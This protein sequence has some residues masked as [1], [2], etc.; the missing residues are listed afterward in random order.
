MEET[1]VNHIRCKRWHTRVYSYDEET[2][3]KKEKILWFT[4]FKDN[5]NE[6][7]RYLE[8]KH[9]IGLRIDETFWGEPKFILEE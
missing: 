4:G 8:E 3:I 6:T 5:Y 1:E 2:G 7:R 9:L